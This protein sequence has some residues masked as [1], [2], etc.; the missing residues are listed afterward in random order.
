M[1]PTRELS[2][3]PLGTGELLDRALGICRAQFRQLFLLALGFQVA[4]QGISKLVEL[5]AYARFPALVSFSHVGE[6]PPA[7]QLLW[8]L[9]TLTG[10]FAVSV[11]LF[12]AS[13]GAVSLGG[14]ASTQLESFSASRCWERLRPRLGALLATLLFELVLLGAQ[15]ALGLLPVGLAALN[16]ARD[17]SLDALVLLALGTLLSLLLAPAIF[18]VGFLRYLLVP[19]CVVV[20]GLSGPRAIRRSIQ[21][22]RAGRARWTMGPKLRASLVLLVV[23]LVVNAVTLIADAPRS[24]LVFSHA[25]GTGS[26]PLYLLAELVSLTAKTAVY[27][28]GMVAL[29]LFYLEVRVRREGIDI[30]LAAE[31]MAKAA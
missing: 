6:L 30:A 5:V 31:G 4:M 24:L 17:G 15:V 19:S 8:A 27:P 14:P 13:V 7:A 21:L 29:A 18:L 12:Q 10:Y 2:L 26:L 16:A 23:A 1:N 28:F 20:E 11:V 3:R 22:M 9:P 25:G